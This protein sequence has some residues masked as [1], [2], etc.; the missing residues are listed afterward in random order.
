MLAPLRHRDFRLLFIGQTVSMVGNQLYSVALPF[1]LLALKG[2]PLQLGTGFA[3]FAGAQ[4]LTTLFGGALVDR[5][6][7]RT[8]TCSMDVPRTSVV[9]V[10]AAA[11][12]T[13]HLQIAHF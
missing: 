5:L 11:R 1:P 2:T 8:V 6:P 7:S 13:P 4:L 9:A 3:F 12:L 10:A